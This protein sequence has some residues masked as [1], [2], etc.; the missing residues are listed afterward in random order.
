[1]IGSGTTSN[2]QANPGD[3]IANWNPSRLIKFIKQL[4]ETDPPAFLPR[5]N[6][7]DLTVTGT[8]SIN[9]QIKFIRDP[10][11]HNIGATGEPAF[12]NSW[13]NFNALDNPASY[14]RDPFGIVH[15]RGL[16]KSGTLTTS[17]FTLPVGFR[18]L[19]QENFGTVSNS[20]FG[21]AT[22][23]NDGKVTPQ[24]GSTTWFSLD[25]LTFKAV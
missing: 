5:A 6:I 20:A 17:A 23:T 25:G 12:T 3:T 15:L 14:W 2:N 22:V 24:A 10:N 1:M 4:F 13:V 8:L 18:P 21:Y 9:D 19:V 11:F 7:Q 16:I